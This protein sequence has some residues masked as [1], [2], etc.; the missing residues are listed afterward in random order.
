MSPPFA[1]LAALALAAVLAGCGVNP[2]PG[3]QEI[4]FVSESQELQIG[5]SQYAPTRQGEGGDYK[6]LPDLT[7][8]V[9]EV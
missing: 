8:Y 7:A 4:Q 3:K 1:R 2:V 5:A 9:S 6:T